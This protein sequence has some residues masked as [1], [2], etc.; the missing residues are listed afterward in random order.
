[1]ALAAHVPVRFFEG[2]HEVL[3]Q[4]HLEW[5][6]DQDL[7][8]WGRR[9]WRGQRR[10]IESPPADCIGL[11][12]RARPRQRI[13]PYE[14]SVLHDFCPMVVPWAFTS[15]ARELAVKILTENILASDIVL[16]DSRSTKADAAMFC[17]LDQERIIVAPP[18][19]SLCLETHRHRGSVSRSDRIALA[20]STIEPRKNAPFLFEW[21]HDTKLLPPDMELW[22]VGRLG[23]MISRREIARMASRPGGRRIRL[24]GNVSDARLCELYQTASWSIYP[25]RYE[26][27]GFP[28][29]DSLRHGTPVLS[30]GTSSMGEFDHPGVFFFDPQDATTVD[31]AWLRLQESRTGMISRSRLDELYSWDLVARTVLEAHGQHARDIPGGSSR[32][33]QPRLAAAAAGLAQGAPDAPASTAPEVAVGEHAIPRTRLRIGMEMFGT[34]TGS[35]NRGIGRYSRNLAAAILERDSH[36]EYVIYCQEG[37]PTDHIPTAP[38]AVTRSLRPDQAR[39]ESTL[40]HA[41]ERI[42]ETN[43]DC[44]DVLFLLNPLEL[45]PGYDLPAKPLN[46]LRMASVAY[47]LIPLIFQ[48]EYFP[49]SGFARR[50]QR[51]LT[52]LRSY[53]ALLALSEATRDDFVSLLGLSPE[54]VVTIG[55]ASNGPAFVP[56]RT[57]PMPDETRRTLGLLGVTRPFVFSVGDAEYRKNPWGLIDAFAMLPDEMKQSHQLV[58]SY[59]LRDGQRT[60]VRQYAQDRGVTDALVLTDWLSDKGLRPLYQRCSAFVFPSMYEG[61]GLPILEAMHCGAPVIAGNNSSQIEVVG[62][63]GLLFNVAD[64]GELAGHLTR[65]LQDPD[66]AREMGERA[67]VRA[68]HFSWEATADKTLKVLTQ[69]PSSE[70]RAMPRP[71]RRSAS[72]RRIAF[73]SPLHPL[74]SPVADD[75]A[76]LLEALKGRYTIDLYHDAGQLPYAGLQSADFGCHDCR[77]F[78]R[79]AGVL[80]YHAVIYQMASSPYHGYLYDTLLRHPGIVI[81]HDLGLADFHFWY[82][83]QPG[84]D[85]DVHLRQEF[86]AYF[87][88]RADKVL[89]SLTPWK[90]APGG[91][92]QACEQQGYHLNGRILDRAT[93]VIVHSPWCVEQVRNQF[94]IHIEKISI[95]P[96]GATAED[97]TPEQRRAIR[98]R[99]GMAQ[100][101]LIIASLGPIHAMRMGTETIEAF[102]PVAREIPAALLVFAGKEEDGGE[103][104]RKAMELGLQRQVRFLGHR[105][106]S[107]VNDLATIADIGVCL[108]RPPA[109]GE[110]AGALLDL[111]RLGVPTV[112]SDVV[113]F[114]CYPDSVILKHRWDEDGLDRLIRALRELA[115]N[116]AQREALGRAAGRH[117]EQYHSWSRTADSYEEIIERTVTRRTQTQSGRRSPLPDS[118]FVASSERLQAAS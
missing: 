26:G 50:Y 37:L 49:G 9:I 42:A 91:I 23:W 15:D 76:G 13:F 20:V 87:G 98:A 102:A 47:D 54:Q 1:M 100:E 52:R 68:R 67:V 70:S 46:G 43:P 11:Y 73:F 45:F 79:N 19:P 16:S 89:R 60:R 36:N 108:R 114:S 28:I 29:L 44:I 27:F 7:E 51:S 62:N 117:V 111:L 101:A 40:A 113:S 18:G 14:A 33:V 56:D 80:G 35:R 2:H 97:P 64:A 34:Q 57:E 10:L 32:S 8:H 109:K 48:E 24:L 92:P 38:N 105:P 95:V 59:V 116:P 53:N 17:A 66:L 112:V 12:C 85:G 61:F 104:R 118:Q 115:V 110:I 96:F 21:F 78:E 25:S 77:L 94:P 106:A 90:N 82:A 63:A 5:S 22:W 107:V 30:S 93:H 55:A 74:S 3:A 31:Q 41:M 4:E 39:G 99:F 75:S 88:A 86:E 6:P 71:L 58:L 103:A 72:P 69:L 81:L 83:Q 65:L 84:V